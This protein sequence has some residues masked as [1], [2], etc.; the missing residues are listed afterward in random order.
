MTQEEFTGKHRERWQRLEVMLAQ[1]NRLDRKRIVQLT[2]I[3]DI[4]EFDR[5]YRR[6][7]MHLALARQRLYTGELIDYLNELA[8]KSNRLFYEQR[9]R[10]LPGVLRFFAGE[11]PALVRSQ[12]TVVWIA[13]LLFL[14]PAI[15][16]LVALEFEPDLIH[17]IIGAEQL[18]GIEEMYAP[19]A[20]FRSWEQ[21]ASSDLQMFGFYILNNIGI[22]F[23][24]FAGGIVFGIGSILVVVFNGL[25]FGA[26]AGH[27]YGIG[28]EDQF[29]PFVAGHSAP[30]LTAIVLCG[31]AG[32]KLGWSFMAPGRLARLESLKRGAALSVKIVSGAAAMLLLAACIEAFWSARAEISD[33]I[34]I[35]AGALGWMLT[36]FYFMF[37]GRD[38]EP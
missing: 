30:E 21:E 12:A 29:L 33:V 31:A 10:Y 20:E 1:A 18:R 25:F 28:Y 3:V 35:C 15:G 5:E 37:M 6:V 23:R 4:A 34:K 11:F 13:T 7:C 27:L 24:T 8:L 19:G 38:V 2:D 22:G 16:M 32:L 14:L 17:S 26:V 9:R 36:L